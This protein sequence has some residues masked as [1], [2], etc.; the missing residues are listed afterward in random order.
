MTQAFGSAPGVQAPTRD[1]HAPEKR[2]DTALPQIVPVKTK[3]DGTSWVLFQTSCLSPPG[4]IQEN[5]SPLP[6]S[7]TSLPKV[8]SR[9]GARLGAGEGGQVHTEVQLF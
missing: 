2:L 5:E 4:L 6:L 8:G 3:I 9:H 1:K 7:Q